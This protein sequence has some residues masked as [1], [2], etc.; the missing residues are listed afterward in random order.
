NPAVVAWPYVRFYAGAPLRT[1]LGHALG[2]LCVL[3]RVPRKLSQVQA[4][5]LAQLRDQVM[6]L[7]EMRRELLELRRSEAL[8]QEAVE[9]LLASQQDLRARVELRTREVEE[10]HKKTRQL[11][12]R[13]GDGF[14]A[15]D[16]NWNYVYV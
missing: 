16:R 6:E 4:R 7:F 12:E 10:A 14:V 2:T 5:A 9:A 1:P 15:L 3:D 13:I 8:R 11:L